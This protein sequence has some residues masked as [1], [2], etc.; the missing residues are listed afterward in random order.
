MMRYIS[1]N[2]VNKVFVESTPCFIL[3]FMKQK[4]ESNPS[5]TFWIPWTL[6]WRRK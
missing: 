3:S 2:A 5:L 4:M 1:Y 6:K